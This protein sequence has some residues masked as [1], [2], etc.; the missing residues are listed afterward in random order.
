[1]VKKEQKEFTVYIDMKCSH[2]VHVKAVSVTD[3]KEKAF[4]KFK[5]TRDKKS[6]YD[7]SAEPGWM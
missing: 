4:D 3:A 5:K 2:T 7:I 6:S 1:M